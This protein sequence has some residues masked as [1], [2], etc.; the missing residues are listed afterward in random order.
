MKR[1]VSNGQAVAVSAGPSKCGHRRHTQFQFVCQKRHKWV[2][3]RVVLWLQVARELE[4]PFKVWSSTYNCLPFTAV[5]WAF[6]EDIL[7]FA[8]SVVSTNIV[9]AKFT[10][11]SVFFVCLA[12]ILCEQQ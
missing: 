11:R 7:A 12:D 1:R 2:A 6:N 5:Q 8:Y 3:R 4:D 10:L 9:L